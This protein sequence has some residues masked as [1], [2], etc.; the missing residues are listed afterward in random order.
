MLTKFLS[1]ERIL[2]NTH[3]IKIRFDIEID[4]LIFLCTKLPNHFKPISKQSVKKFRIFKKGFNDQ[5][6]FK[7]KKIEL[8][9]NHDVK[10]VEYFIRDYFIKD[11]T[12]V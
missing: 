9:T 8:T 11:K 1:S 2:A 7:I 6:V 4:W 10:A 3:L 5:Y 12:L